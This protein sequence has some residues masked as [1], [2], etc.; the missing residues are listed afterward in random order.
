MVGAPG[1]QTPPS[2]RPLHGTFSLGLSM[3]DFTLIAELYR[4]LLRGCASPIFGNAA[5]TLPDVLLGARPD[6]GGPCLPSVGTVDAPAGATGAVILAES[7]L[8]VPHLAGT[9]RGDA[10]DLYVLQLQPGQQQ[11]CA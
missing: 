7:H 2:L 9:A 5:G 3:R 4:L 1:F 10:L 11:C 6:A 8:A